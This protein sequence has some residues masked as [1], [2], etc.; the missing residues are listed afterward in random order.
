MGMY[1]YMFF[2]WLIIA[3]TTKVLPLGNRCCKNY[4]KKKTRTR[5]SPTIARTSSP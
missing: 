2:A 1:A 3:P 4:G 5:S